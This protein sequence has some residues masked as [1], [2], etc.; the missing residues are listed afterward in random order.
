[1]AKAHQLTSDTTG[2]QKVQAP[3]PY[4]G[5]CG[6]CALQ[7]LAYADQL[8]V[9]RARLASTLG[10]HA[11]ALPPVDV[12]GMED[13]W[14]YRNK[15]E[16][17]FGAS[18]DALS[19]GFHAARSFTRIVDLEDC[20]LVPEPAMRIA[21]DARARCAD[22]GWPPYH[23]RT[24]QGT[25]RYLI[26]RHSRATGQ[27]AA[28]LITAQAPRDPIERMA[29]QLGQ[30]HQELAMFV[31]GV[32]DRA[33]DVAV[34]DTVDRLYGSETFEDRIGPF[35]VEV[36]PHTFLQTSSAQAER[37]YAT[38]RDWLAA[39]GR[40]AWDLYGGIGLLGF[41]LSPYFGTVH[42]IEGDPASSWLAGVNAQRNGIR[43][44]RAHPGAVEEVLRDRRFWLQEGK[45]DAVVIDPPRNGM[46]PAAVDAVLSARPQ[47]IVYVSCNPQTLARDLAIL[48]GSFP[49]YRIEAWL[50]FDMF[51]HT[52]HVEVC[53]KLVRSGLN[54]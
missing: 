2:F 20:L 44:L 3:C 54:A 37:L 35:R 13:P 48:L 4:F 45:P 39:G 42:S 7:D 15:A 25:L 14:R 49:R 51:P 19:L 28:S 47:A 21:R 38:V 41:H 6:G 9:K 24:H 33:S 16:F 30:A 1:M 43:N 18:G 31:W 8:A 17:T 46:H 52:P 5:T 23:P 29:Q 12:I 50:G 53:V 40:V 34:P 22:L 11:P 32:T 36:D 27:V 26:V 10:K